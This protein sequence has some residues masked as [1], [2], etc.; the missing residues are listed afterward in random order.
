VSKLILMPV[1]PNQPSKT[2]NDLEK[3]YKDQVAPGRKTERRDVCRMS[4]L[5]H[6][7]KEKIHQAP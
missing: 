3:Y 5:H 4:I 2:M 7:M 6:F 1:K